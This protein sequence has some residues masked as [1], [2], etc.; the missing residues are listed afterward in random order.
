MAAQDIHN[1]EAHRV[2]TAHTGRVQPIARQ[3]VAEAHPEVTGHQV[4][5]Q[6]LTVRAVIIVL[7]PEVL[8]EAAEV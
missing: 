8:T 2:T 6:G 4:R 7:H 1:R 5:L 3:P